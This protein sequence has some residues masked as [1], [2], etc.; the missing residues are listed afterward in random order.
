MPT[1]VIPLTNDVGYNV[2]RIEA[3]QSLYFSIALPG[4]AANIICRVDAPNAGQDSDL[5]GKLNAIPD[6][7]TSFYDRVSSAGGT[8]ESFAYPSGLYDDLLAVFWLPGH[9]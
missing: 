4:S 6:R 9:R 7:A 3:G 1:T 8:H 2:P 5:F